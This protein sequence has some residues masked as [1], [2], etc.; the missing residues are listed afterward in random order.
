M[1]AASSF[2]FAGRESAERPGTTW[3]TSAS[4]AVRFSSGSVTWRAMPCTTTE[5]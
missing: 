3:S 4:S 5:R 2:L 1:V